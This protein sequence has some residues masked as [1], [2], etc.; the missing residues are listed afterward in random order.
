LSDKLRVTYVK[1]FREQSANV[2]KK[3]EL[4]I[5][6]EDYRYL[7]GSVEV[8]PLKGASGKVIHSQDEN[9]LWAYTEYQISTQS[10][11]TYYIWVKIS[12]DSDNKN[13][14]YVA[15]NN[16]NNEKMITGS[17]D[18]KFGKKSWQK[19]SFEKVPEGSYPL[20]IRAAHPG[21]RWDKIF[22][23]MDENKQ[24]LD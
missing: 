5:E 9:E 15:F 11:G 19:V 21:V 8:V 6:A 17:S 1:D 2:G 7:V 20:R 18:K 23:T 4:Y 24:P 12:G 16:L 14:A 10:S 22:I 13:E 3:A